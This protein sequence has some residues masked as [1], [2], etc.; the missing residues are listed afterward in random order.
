MP[1]ELRVVRCFQCLKYQVDIVKK[2]NKWAC[3]VCG[4]KQSFTR[5][6]YRGTGKDCRSVIFA[7]TERN[8]TNDRQEEEIAQLVLQGVIQL[9][10]PVVPE[11]RF[12]IDERPGTAHRSDETPN[13]WEPFVEKQ[14]PEDSSDL[15]PCDTSDNG[16]SNSSF[17]REQRNFVSKRLASV[18]RRKGGWNFA[19]AADAFDAQN[20]LPAV[21]LDK[22]TNADE[23][24]PIERNNTACPRQLTNKFVSTNSQPLFG[25]HRKENS[26][27]WSLP[28]STEQVSKQF[29]HSSSGNSAP[30]LSE[31]VSKRKLSNEPAIPLMN[32]AKRVRGKTSLDNSDTHSALTTSNSQTQASDGA[33]KWSKYVPPPDD[34]EG[35][36]EDLFFRF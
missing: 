3:K 26:R 1:Q 36:G 34:T 28:A 33:S 19:N 5:E 14:E 8:I 6:Y 25:F 31:P 22:P 29:N 20:A 16:H 18:G 7:L 2:A 32:F 24:L 4:V 30:A 21:D 9:P 11:T 15:L 17:T 27:K 23:R 13:K 12:D 35:H 10:K